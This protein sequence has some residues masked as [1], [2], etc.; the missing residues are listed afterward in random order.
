MTVTATTNKQRTTGN[1]V[2]VAFPAT[3]K[4]FAETDIKVT[5]INN[6]TDVLVNTLILNDGGALGYTVA[7]DTEAETLTVTVNTAVIAAEDLQI[8]RV[9]P[10]TQ[11]Q[12]F[13]RATKF[14]AKA[15]EDGL[16]K[17]TMVLQDQQ[18]ILNRA[19]VLPE[20]STV[21]DPTLPIPSNRKAL[22]WDPAEDGTIIN[23]AFDPDTQQAASAAS[24]ATAV[25]AASGAATSETNTAADAV[26]TAANVVSTN[27]DVVTSGT[28]AD[29]AEAAASAVGLNYLFDTS[30]SMADPGTGDVRFNNA[31][32]SS[33]TAI[34]FDAQTAETGNPDV[35]DFIATWGD[36]S[37]ADKG[38]ITF[39]KS[40]DSTVFA[41]FSITAAVVDNTG[42]LQ[43]TVIHVDSAGTF[44][45]SDSLYASFSRAGTAGT[46]FS[47]SDITGQTEEVITAADEIVWADASD[48]GNLKKDTIQ[49]I[50]DLVVTELPVGSLYMNSSDA[51][52]PGTLLGY[53]TWVA[54]QDAMI[55][56]ASGTYPAGTT[57]GSAT[58]TP[59]TATTASHDHRLKSTDNGETV[60]Y[61]FG[62]SGNRGQ[63]VCGISSGTKAF[64]SVGG[65]GDDL[66]ENTGSGSAATTLSPYYAAYIWRRTV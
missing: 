48:S 62:D 35:S 29:N 64:Y 21:T 20:E 4:I 34:A 56:G 17:A 38:N 9:L 23:S 58:T 60:N 41:I 55:I 27:A 59:T 44:S 28:N 53:G 26:S 31:T 33:V 14:P 2:T 49:G 19:F 65:T 18:E 66:M 8:L 13:P 57:G 3:I 1:G 54:I 46:G 51:T 5:T 22:L 16:D 10:Q 42:W 7:F 36:S 6:T 43:I 24:A 15:N 61:G 39:R 32:L 50:L 63:T 25:S 11:N 12:D 45:A 37:N 52:N 47:S 40:G 30:T